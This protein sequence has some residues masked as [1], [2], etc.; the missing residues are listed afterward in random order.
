ME[1]A[2]LI[3][4]LFTTP[5]LNDWTKKIPILLM[6]QFGVSLKAKMREKTL[7]LW[8]EQEQERPGSSCCVVF[9]AILYFSPFWT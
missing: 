9:L 7:V 4:F 6:S 1:R 5:Q 2:L 8:K 3:V